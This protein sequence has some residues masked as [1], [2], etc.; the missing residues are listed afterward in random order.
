[1]AVTLPNHEEGFYLPA[2]EAMAAGA[3][4]V[5][6]DCTGNRGFCRD[7]ET[8][9]R[10]RYALDDVVAACLAAVTQAPGDAATMR[11]AAA[12]ETR[13]HGLAAERLAFLRILDAV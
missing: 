11:A 10:P 12:A 4:V 2:L 13:N 8:A 7:L 9:F 5:C 6:P 1:M 3:I